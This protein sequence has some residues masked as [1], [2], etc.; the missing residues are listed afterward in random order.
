MNDATTIVIFSV[1]QLITNDDFEFHPQ[2]TPWVI[3]G[4][5]LKDIFLSLFFGVILAIFA[6]V[7][8]KYLRFMNESPVAEVSVL[9]FSSYLAYLFAESLELSGIIAMLSCGILLAHY[10][11]YNLS[12]IAQQGSSLAF[13]MLGHIC[14]GLIFAYLGLSCMIYENKHWAVKFIFAEFGVLAV[15]RLV[16]IFII[17]ATVRIFRGEKLRLSWKDL[18]VIWFAGLIRGAI[19]FGLVGSISKVP[20]RTIILT[21]VLALVVGSTLI[22]GALCPI[23]VALVG[24]R[25]RS[26]EGDHHECSEERDQPDYSY[27]LTQAQNNELDNSALLAQLPKDKQSLFAPRSKV[28]R[29][30]RK[31][32]DSYVK[33]LLIR[34]A[35][36][37]VSNPVTRENSNEEALACLEDL[38]YSNLQSR[39][40]TPN[41]AFFRQT[42]KIAYDRV[43]HRRAHSF[44]DI[45][46]EEDDDEGE[47]EEEKSDFLN[48]GNGSLN[49]ERNRQKQG[50]EMNQSLLRKNLVL[51][52]KRK[53]DSIRPKNSAREDEETRSLGNETQIEIVTEEKISMK[54]HSRQDQ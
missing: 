5:F 32:D 54:Q 15:S 17:S 38:M 35:N 4:L 40:S 41:R 53:T 16:S 14:E 21:T 2:K 6:S 47:D 8:L 50:S 31:L 29:F 33:P 37:P 10:A 7:L 1:V 44:S 46:T 51:L 3:L 28:H 22:F 19:A 13:G 11:F 52:E 24:L 25:K 36:P 49:S 48:S 23:Y 39:R 20:H 18:A 12:E 9:F 43:V 45:V 26:K 34:D 42:T 30:W 27:L